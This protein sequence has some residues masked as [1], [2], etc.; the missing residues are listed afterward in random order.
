MRNEIMRKRCFYVCSL[1]QPHLHDIKYNKVSKFLQFFQVERGASMWSLNF[2]VE[3]AMK[4]GLLLA[5]L[6]NKARKSLKDSGSCSILTCAFNAQKLKKL[7]I[8]MKKRM[9]DSKNSRWFVP[10]D[11]LSLYGWIYIYSHRS[12][13]RKEIKMNTCCKNSSSRNILCHFEVKQQHITSSNL[14]NRSTLWK[15]L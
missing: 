3:V 1:W 9:D 7:K 2:L 6:K 10:Y 11:I 13:Q 5:V 4:F 12:P 15:D 14:I 8:K